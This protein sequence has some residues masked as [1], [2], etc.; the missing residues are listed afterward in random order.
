MLS[1]KL[2]GYGY[3]GPLVVDTKRSNTYCCRGISAR[4]AASLVYMVY[5]Q[6]RRVFWQQQEVSSAL[7]DLLTAATPQQAVEICLTGSL[8]AREDALPRKRLFD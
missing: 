2:N 1:R 7:R 4:T 5:L 8:C 6:V 3:G